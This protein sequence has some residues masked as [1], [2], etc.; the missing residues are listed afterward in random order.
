MIW[1]CAQL[2]VE[3]YG[4][5]YEVG[6]VLGE[7]AGDVGR[8]LHGHEEAQR[9]VF[10]PLRWHILIQ[11]M[12]EHPREALVE[13]LGVGNSGFSR[14]AEALQKVGLGDGMPRR[15]N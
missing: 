13:I 3:E 8:L 2:Q 11:D 5:L 4:S 6:L 1:S 15:C 9:G 14:I 7:G 10:S 12:T